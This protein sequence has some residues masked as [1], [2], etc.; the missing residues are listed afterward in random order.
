[1]AAESSGA[2]CND[3][4]AKNPDRGAS[5]QVPSPTLRPASNAAMLPS[6]CIS[7][8][9][10]RTG[11]GQSARLG[12]WQQRS[13]MAS[14]TSISVPHTGQNTVRMSPAIARLTPLPLAD[15]AARLAATTHLHQP[16]RRLMLAE[17]FADDA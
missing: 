17:K 15:P 13:A 10:I 12:V 7:P 2:A 9:S 5:H 6:G 4:T 16:L 11:S 8:G 14:R 3:A 1:M